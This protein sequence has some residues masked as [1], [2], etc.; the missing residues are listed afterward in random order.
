MAGRAEVTSL[1]GESQKD[2][3]LAVFALDPGKAFF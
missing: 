3:V 2:F 1:S